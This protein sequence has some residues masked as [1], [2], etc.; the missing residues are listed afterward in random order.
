MNDLFLCFV[1][2]I[3]CNDVWALRATLLSIHCY[4][5]SIYSTVLLKIENLPPPHPQL[6]PEK[7]DSQTGTMSSLSA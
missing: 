6:R 2:Y 4:P 1:Y 5:H 7:T 3:F